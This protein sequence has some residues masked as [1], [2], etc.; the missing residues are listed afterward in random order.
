M[1]K[2]QF[3]KI[4]SLILIMAMLLSVFSVTAGAVEEIP[5]TIS[6]SSS[7][8][9][10]GQEVEVFINVKNNPGI[11]SMSLS[12]SFESELTLK[13]VEYNKSFDGTAMKPEKLSS[14]VTLAWA[15]PLEN[16]NE[17]GTFAKLRFMINKNVQGNSETSIKLDFDPENIYNV[18]KTE[19]SKSIRIFRAM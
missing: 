14:P 19:P 2:N 1:M 17:N 16:C 13:S 12:V 10:V 7:S 11:N 4:C 5:M 8:G 15:N 6:V 3:K 18:V 9:A